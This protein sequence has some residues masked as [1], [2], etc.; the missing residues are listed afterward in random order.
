MSISERV[1][2][3]K[4]PTMR[5]FGDTVANIIAFL[6]VIV[7]ITY[8]ASG[9]LGEFVNWAIETTT[10]GFDELS[11]RDQRLLFRNHWFG[12]VFKSFE[13]GFLL[14][15]GLILGLPI[16]LSFA[17]SFLN[18]KQPDGRHWVNICLAGLSTIVFSFWIISLFAVDGGALPSARSV[19]YILLIVATILTLYLTWRNFGSFIVGFCLFWI[20]YFFIRG[21]LPEWTGI[22]AGS[23]SSFPQSMRSMVLNFWAQTGG[24]FGQPLQVVSGNVLIFIVFGAVL[25][26]SGAG[27]LLMKI[28]NRMTG[29]LTGGAA[30]AAVASSALF[31][32]LSG[33]AI[34]NVVSTGV[35]TIPVIKKSGFK[36]AFA[37]AVEAAASTGGQ[38]MPPVMGVVAFFVA[39]QIGLEY[40]YIVV[41]AIIPAIFFYLGTFLTVYFESRRQ[42]VGPLPA[43]SRPKLNREELIQCLVFILPL[44][45]L[46][47]YLFAQPSVPKAGFYGFVVALICSLIFFPKFRSLDK[48]YSAFVNAGKMSASIVVIV[49]TIGLVVGL[50]QVSGFSGRLSL[51]LAQLASGPLLGTLVVVAL[52]SIV[53]GMGLPPGA[54]YFIIVIALSSGIDAVGVA[55]LTLHLF[56]VFFAVISTVTPP[57][58]LAA[59]AAAPIAGA[60]PIETGFQAARLAIAG[61]IIP[62]V[63]VYH[64]AVLYK[65]QILFEWFGEDPISS[66]AMIDINTVSWADLGWIMLAFSIS[67]WLIA[68]ALTGY[69]KNKLFITERIIRVAAALGILVPDLFIAGPAF[70]L[71]I[72]LIVGHRYLK[73]QP[74]P[75]DIPS[76]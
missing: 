13:R 42:G 33:A 37:G 74:S 50:I 39:G 52:G 6:F 24:M 48:L 60:D 71:S 12:G 31:G 46:S 53:L 69:E 44:G 63:F 19:D 68:S 64:P 30:H 43:E 18:L 20:I 21:L 59:F 58:A 56:V 9:P 14:P 73:G 47:Y 5:M 66:K 54:T 49:T 70:I 15:T 51:L 34:S 35:M 28:A 17:I 38:I 26:A 25:M 45:T 62:F 23:E 67:M 41:A 2:S 29:G 8:A 55:P 57:V 4:K 76:A 72:V 10:S 65:L 11:R 36:P 1:E 3:V 22:F 32:T 75:V 40:R 7:I 16:T 61:F 27:D